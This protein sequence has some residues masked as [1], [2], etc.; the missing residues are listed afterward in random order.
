MAVQQLVDTATAATQTNAPVQLLLDGDHTDELLG[1]PVSE[2]LARGDF[3]DTLSLV[4]VTSPAEGA[5]VEGSFRAEGI[6]SSFEATV[7]WQILDGEEVVEEGF[8]TADGWMDRLYPWRTDEIDV[9]DLAPG[10]Y[11]FVARTDDPSGGA[12]G[13]GPFEDTKT[14]TVR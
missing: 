9:S 14:I 4:M 13:A 1:V 5:V 7:P 10:D 12:E 6:A 3:L 11:T 8:S 2:P